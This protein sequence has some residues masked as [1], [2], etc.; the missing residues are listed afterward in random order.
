[1]SAEDEWT[2]FASLRPLPRRRRRG[3]AGSTSCQIVNDAR[4]C[5]LF[6]MFIGYGPASTIRIHN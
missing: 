6:S 5:D 2:G 3:F 4:V 1:M